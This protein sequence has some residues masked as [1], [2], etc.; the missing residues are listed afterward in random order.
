MRRHF[1]SGEDFS[2]QKISKIMTKS[3]I[4]IKETK[5]AAEAFEILRDKKIDEIPVIDAKGQLAGILD[6]QDIL[7]AG[8]V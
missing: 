1:E 7:K 4:T 3:P 6:V 5:L 8:L 2:T